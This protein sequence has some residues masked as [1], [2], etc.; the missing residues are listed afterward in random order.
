MRVDEGRIE[1][2]L[3]PVNAAVA[4]GVLLLALLF[5]YQLGA[6]L[7]GDVDS[8]PSTDLAAKNERPGAEELDQALSQTPDPGVIIPEGGPRASGTG[9]STAGPVG[10]GVAVTPPGQEQVVRQAGLNY[11]ILQHFKQEDRA[12][13]LHAQA[14]LES[15]NVPTTVERRADGWDLVST[16]GFDYGKASDKTR[17]Q[18]YIRAVQTLGQE[19][20]NAYRG[21][22]VIRYD[23]R[24]P[25]ARKW[26]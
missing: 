26:N 25:Y 19:Y 21:Q 17:C 24:D 23:F 20:V 5:S 13:A 14:W 9:S 15:Q 22:R 7:A 8:R 6:N 11:V 1:I 4:G 2:S 10:P 18:E 12:D 16:V 3:T